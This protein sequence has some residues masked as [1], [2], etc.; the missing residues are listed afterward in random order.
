MKGHMILLSSSYSKGTR[1][2][3]DFLEEDFKNVQGVI[4]EI[5][6]KCNGDM[7]VSLHMIGTDSDSWESVKKKDPYFES[8]ELITD[9]DE[10]IRL[11]LKD[12]ALK[13]TDVAKYILSDLDGITHLKLEK[14]CYL[15][16][17]D[18]LC[19]TSGKKLFLDK[20]YAYK[21]GPVVGSVYET[22]KEYAGELITE[23]AMPKRPYYMSARS[24]ILFAE[25][26]RN[27]LRS[28]TRT[29]EKYKGYSAGNLINLTHQNGAPWSHY[30]SSLTN[31]VMEDN[32]ILKYHEIESV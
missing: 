29:L 19:E 9:K 30:D 28:I 31:E 13:G 23:K 22:Y 25:D 6:F 5:V 11:I 3:L 15:C 24:R 4:D 7:P 10:F 1:I 27:K 14:L 20:I 12:R 18:Y 16:Y 8:V 26:G 21:Y 17:A 2:A 32:V